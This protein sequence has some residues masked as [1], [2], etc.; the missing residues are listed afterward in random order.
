MSIFSKIKTSFCKPS[1]APTA[2][3]YKEEINAEAF[4]VIFI[5]PIYRCYPALIHSLTAQTYQNW[6]LLLVHDGPGDETFQRHCSTIDDRRVTLLQTPTHAGNWGHTPRQFAFEH[7]RNSAHPGDFIVVTNADNYHVP[8]FTTQML[9]AFDAEKDMVYCDMLHNLF[10]WQYT[11]TK[12]KHGEIDCGCCMIRS[13]IAL[14]V[15]WRNTSYDGDWVFIHDL[16][17]RRGNNAI[18]HVPRPLFVHN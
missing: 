12:L 10:S 2:T 11:Q 6:Q 3:H 15:G 18:R 13:N 16:L 7:L 17:K 1:T 8:G 14:E 5:A 9:E 4:K